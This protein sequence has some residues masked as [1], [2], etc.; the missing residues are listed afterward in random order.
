MF[1]GVYGD[2]IPEIESSA[3]LPQ[4]NECILSSKCLIRETRV[5]IYPVGNII[6]VLQ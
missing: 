2:M 4:S 5:G 3:H 1:K 6:V